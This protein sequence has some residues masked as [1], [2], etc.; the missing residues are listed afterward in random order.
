MYD[1]V[2]S[3]PAPVG[4]PARSGPL[5]VAR[6]PAAIVVAALLSSYTLPA[7]RIH[8]PLPM[9]STLASA[10]IFTPFA[11]APGSAEPAISPVDARLMNARRA[12]DAA[13]GAGLPYRFAG[14]EGDRQRALTCL[15]AAAWYEAGDDP[16]GERAVIQV[17]LNRIRHA[18]YPASVCGAVFQ[19]SELSTGCQFTFTCDG[20]LVRRPGA[21]AWGR[22]RALAAAAL[23]G[24]VDPVV[25]DA[26]HYHADYVYP[27]W[28]PTLAKLATVGAHVFY[29]F[30]WGGGRKAAL[31]VPEPVVPQLVAIFGEGG[32]VPAEPGPTAPSPLPVAA[33]LVPAHPTA[34]TPGLIPGP[35]ASQRS[36][37]IMVAVDPAVPAGRWAI[38]AMARCAGKTDCAVIG[39]NSPAL[40]ESNRL[41]SLSDQDRPVFVFTRSRASRT[42]MALW[43]CSA[44]SRPDARQCLP[45]DRGAVQRLL[46]AQQHQ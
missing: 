20:A 43:D 29:R 15:A 17:V 25:G 1:L 34:L 9:S 35:S 39:W 32:E 11:T 36:S 31:G 12:L 30:P 18:A 19:G 5:G 23:D 22:A 33:A 40:L 8:I 13:P 38:D 14:S 3:I 37:A 41:R 6:G 24:A 21:A 10:R 45:A 27:Y 16:A 2:D 4:R 28:A 26:T 7:D 46:R 42:E 44:V